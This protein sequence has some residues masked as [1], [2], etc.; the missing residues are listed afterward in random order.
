MS[1]LHECLSFFKRPSP[2]FASVGIPEQRR[3]L[4]CK[5][6]SSAGRSVSARRCRTNRG[7]A[8][9]RLAVFV[10]LLV[11]AGCLL[12]ADSADILSRSFGSRRLIQPDGVW[13]DDTAFTESFAQ[14][15]R[16]FSPVRR[17]SLA[18]HRQ[19]RCFMNLTVPVNHKQLLDVLLNVGLIRPVVFEKLGAEYVRDDL[20]CVLYH[21]SAWV[22]RGQLK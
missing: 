19:R 8:L 12:Q 15:T 5:M 20:T 22:Q 16:P 9:L 7:Q 18:R 4:L 6:T 17:L 2:P 13:Y 3:H 1:T 14:D 10:N 21:P 11:P